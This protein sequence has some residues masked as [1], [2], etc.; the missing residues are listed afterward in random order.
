ME[1]WRTS[2]GTSVDP[3]STDGAPGDHDATREAFRD[4]RDQLAGWQERLYAEDAQSLLMV[5]Q[6][7]DGGGKD[8]TI[9]K[10]FRGVNPQ[11]CRV[12]S[13]KVPSDDELDH[14]ILW[15]VHK[16][17]PAKGEIGIFNRSH[18]E[19]VLV[20]RVHELVPE[21][22]WRARYGVIN[23]FE[24]GLAAAGTR[25]VKFFLHIS[26]DEQARRF[27]KRKADP[28]K[29]W[30]YKP[31][32]EKEREYWADYQAAFS[33]A[34]ANTSTD[35]APWYV[36]PADHKWY[37]NWAVAKILVDTLADMNPQYPA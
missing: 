37:R 21:A 11:G 18:Y 9:K 36:I 3:G 29:R 4:L 32:D 23:D 1:L 15:R 20:V 17:A 12:T 14:D 35:E 34:I 16:A 10:V 13:F 30:K 22:V 33:E 28:T 2:D 7:I 5:L 25:I 27:E 31:E 6:A 26:K 19:D 24:H 8:S